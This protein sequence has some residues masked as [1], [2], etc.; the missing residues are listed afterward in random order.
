MPAAQDLLPRRAFGQ[1][2]MRTVLVLGGYG[3]FGHRI[4][5]ALTSIE[6]LRVLVGGR[7]L[8]RAKAATRTMGLAVEHAVAL[9]AH[10]RTQDQRAYP[11]GARALSV[12]SGANPQLPEVDQPSRIYGLQVISRPL[13]RGGRAWRV[14]SREDLVGQVSKERP[15]AQGKVGE[16]ELHDTP[17]QARRVPQA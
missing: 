15:K 6:S 4:A 3:F 8:E 7:D 17:Q 2:L 11:C 1:E 14:A 16:K 13:L 10:A 12:A 5:A 9:D